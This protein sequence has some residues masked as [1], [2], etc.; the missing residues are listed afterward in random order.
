MPTA[1]NFGSYRGDAGKIPQQL[2]G[3]NLTENAAKLEFAKID[4]DYLVY[5]LRSQPLQKQFFEKIVQMAQPK[6]ALHRIESSII[7][8]PPLAEQ[9]RIVKKIEEIMVL[10]N[11]LR[12]VV[13]GNK[14]QGRGRPKK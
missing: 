9:K 4:Q 8:L 3:A 7:P 14:T 5:I 1:N 11:Q 13:G 6:L 12:D 10:I 2:H